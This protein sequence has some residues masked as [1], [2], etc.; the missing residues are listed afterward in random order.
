MLCDMTEGQMKYVLNVSG[1]W[2]NNIMQ[3]SSIWEKN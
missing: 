1:F 3:Y 2:Y